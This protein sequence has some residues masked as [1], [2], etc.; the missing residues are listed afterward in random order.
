MK[1]VHKV[2][3]GLDVHKKVIVATVATT[4]SQNITTYKTK[5]FP[6]FTSDLYAFADWLLQ[7]NC[8]LV[9]MESTGKYF[10]PVYRVLEEKGLKPFVAHPKFCALFPAKRRTRKT[11][12]GLRIYSSMIWFR[13]VIYL[14]DRSS[15]LEI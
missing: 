1:I 7:H 13:S 14:A 11:V 5:D 6:T 10:I 4:D 12:N 3:C 15:S 2:C 9:C 8:R